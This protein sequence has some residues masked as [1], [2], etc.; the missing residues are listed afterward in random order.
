MAEGPQI[1]LRTERLPRKLAGREVLTC[2]TRR[3]QLVEDVTGLIGSRVGRVFP[4]HS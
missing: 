1:K 2:D 3:P 4:S